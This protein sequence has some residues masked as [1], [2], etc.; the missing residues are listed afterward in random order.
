M[1]ILDVSNNN[2]TA[3]GCKAISPILVSA[4]IL[5]LK[6]DGNKINDEGRPVGVFTT[7]F[8]LGV[9]YITDSLHC[10]SNWISGNKELRY[11]TVGGTNLTAIVRYQTHRLIPA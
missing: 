7:D 8:V 10:P 6:L 5:G 3:T 4:G 11:L 1:R 2:I 9:A